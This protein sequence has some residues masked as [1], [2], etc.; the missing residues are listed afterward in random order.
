MP[1]YNTLDFEQ[2]DSQKNKKYTQNQNNNKEERNSFENLKNV[3]V[4]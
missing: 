1:I 3:L 4:Q 2:H